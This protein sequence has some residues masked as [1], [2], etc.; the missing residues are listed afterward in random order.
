MRLVRFRKGGY[1]WHLLVL[2]SNLNL[3]LEH[4]SDL[5]LKLRSEAGQLENLSTSVSNQ[6]S[7]LNSTSG[8]MHST[9]SEEATQ[10]RQR[11][12]QAL[13]MLDNLQRH[14]RPT[15]AVPFHKAFSTEEVN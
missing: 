6:L 14:R 5:A 3:D 8:A 12:D 1:Q 4:I 11:H 7:A 2:L 10:L 15:G 9:M 13:D